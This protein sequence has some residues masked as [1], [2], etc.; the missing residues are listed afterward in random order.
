MNI[1][2]LQLVFSY[3]L[4]VI[5]PPVPDLQLLQKAAA[6]KET[7]RSLLVHLFLIIFHMGFCEH[8]QILQQLRI[9]SSCRLSWDVLWNW[10]LSISDVELYLF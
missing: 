6:Q 4:R 7:T 3:Q 1:F 8:A 9:Y 5:S 10:Q 2:S